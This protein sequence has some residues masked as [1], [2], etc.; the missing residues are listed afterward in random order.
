M[1]ESPDEEADD[2][3]ICNIDEEGRDQR[4]DDKGRWSHTITFVTAV[5]LAMAVG[6]APRLMPLN[7]AEITASR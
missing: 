7:P 4:Q 2:H 1:T 5:M 3:G 6:V